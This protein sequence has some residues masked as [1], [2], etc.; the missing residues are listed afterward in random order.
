MPGATDHREKEKGR[1]GVVNGAPIL[2]FGHGLSATTQ[3][4]GRHPRLSRLAQK[5]KK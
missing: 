5:E 4:G 1:I 2:L 3:E